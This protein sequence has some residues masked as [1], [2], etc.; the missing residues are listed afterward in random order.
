MR[1]SDWSS[2][3]CS[4]DFVRSD[5]G[6]MAGAAAPSGPAP[7]GAFRLGAG[8]ALAGAGRF[9]LDAG[10]GGGR[11]RG[12]PWRAGDDVAGFGENGGLVV[13]VDQAEIGRAHV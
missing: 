3:V 8:A 5:P 13:G 12:P 1:I 11:R 2:D 7:A 9:R 4:S 6:R 10:R